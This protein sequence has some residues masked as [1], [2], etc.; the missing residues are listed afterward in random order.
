MAWGRVL[1]SSVPLWVQSAPLCRHALQGL[2]LSHLILRARHQSQ[3]LDTCFR[4]GRMG[5]WAS[6]AFA[7]VTAP[8]SLDVGGFPEY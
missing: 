7:P 8:L 3:A 5:T 1:G 6:E 2:P 4:V